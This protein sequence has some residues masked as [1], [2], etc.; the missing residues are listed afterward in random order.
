ML[1]Y[2][3]CKQEDKANGGY[4]NIEGAERKYKCDKVQIIIISTVITEVSLFFLLPGLLIFLSHF[5]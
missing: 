2:S 3:R 4:S 1:I 5:S